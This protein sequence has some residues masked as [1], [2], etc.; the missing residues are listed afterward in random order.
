MEVI[1]D[2]CARPKGSVENK[3][4]E[5]EVLEVLWAI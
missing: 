2:Q 3:P 1:P 4:I 5:P